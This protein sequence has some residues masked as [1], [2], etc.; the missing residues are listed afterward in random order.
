MFVLWLPIAK[1]NFTQG[2]A[3]NRLCSQFWDYKLYVFIFLRILLF[4][5]SISFNNW[6][7]I[8]FHVRKF[9]ST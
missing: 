9:V 4:P 7:L 3:R 5:F 6:H 8:W 1:R 2:I